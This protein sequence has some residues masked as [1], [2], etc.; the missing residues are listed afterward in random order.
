MA[1]FRNGSKHRSDASR[2]SASP[3]A[4]PPIRFLKPVFN[5]I[6]KSPP[7]SNRESVDISKLSLASPPRAKILPQSLPENI[8]PPGRPSPPPQRRRRPRKP[9]IPHPFQYKTPETSPRRKPQTPRHSFR[10]S[11]NSEPRFD[12]LV[13]HGSP[14]RPQDRDDI[15]PAPFGGY[16]GEY[17]PFGSNAAPLEDDRNDNEENYAPYNFP[18][19]VGEENEN[20]WVFPFG[21]S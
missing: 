3:V 8:C 7:R 15:D 10:S 2:L 18:A 14:S 11:R 21:A 20:F 13:G 9:R 19:P 12:D 16:D 6:L 5:G 17:D 1:P 4:P